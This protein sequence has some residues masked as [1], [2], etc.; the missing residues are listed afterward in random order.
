M[1][2]R[3]ATDLQLQPH[4]SKNENQQWH[5]GEQHYNTIAIRVLY[6]DRVEDNAFLLLQQS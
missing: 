3:R 1:G 4:Q 5:I 6:I 2:D